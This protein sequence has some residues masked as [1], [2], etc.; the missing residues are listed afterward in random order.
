[1]MLFLIICAVVENTSLIVASIM[2]KDLMTMVKTTLND[3]LQ[4]IY[5][6]LNSLISHFCLS[7]FWCIHGTYHVFY[8]TR[9]TSA[10]IG[11][12]DYPLKC[13]C[14][15]QMNILLKLIKIFNSFAAFL[16]M[17]IISLKCS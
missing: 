15:K 6:S 10:N 1:M 13:I 17:I 14:R 16:S 5:I 7:E 2:I 4:V 11:Y 8:G 3:L 12:L 9:G